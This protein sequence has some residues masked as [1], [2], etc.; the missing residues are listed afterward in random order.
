MCKNCHRVS[1]DIAQSRARQ[2]SEELEASMSETSVSR[3]PESIEQTDSEK[4]KSPDSECEFANDLE[5]EVG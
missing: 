4:E 2:V 5:E 1:A 3:C